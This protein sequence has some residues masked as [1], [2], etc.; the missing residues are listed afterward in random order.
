MLAS[1]P[2]KWQSLGI[3]EETEETDVP[4]AGT[5]K[6]GGEIS[7]IDWGNPGHKPNTQK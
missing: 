2:D 5:K 3:Q 6:R 4:K 7:K 1:S